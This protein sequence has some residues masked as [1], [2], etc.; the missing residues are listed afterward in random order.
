MNLRL[1]HINHPSFSRRFTQI[2]LIFC[3]SYTSVL[4][5]G[6]E[7][8]F[9]SSSRTDE[10]QAIIQT[11]D[12]GYLSV[13]ST[14]SFGS[15]NDT[16][17]FVVKTDVD[18]TTVWTQFYDEAF[19]E[20]AYDVVQ[21][22]DGGFL[23]V[24]DYEESP[25]VLKDAYLIKISASGDFL[26]SK[27]L[28]HDLEETIASITPGI[29]G[30]FLLAGES[31]DPISGDS[32]FLLIKIDDEGNEAWFKTIGSDQND[33]RINAITSIDNQYVFVGNT[34]RPN[35]FDNDVAVRAVDINGDPIWEGDIKSQLIEEGNDIISTT[36]GALV[37]TGMIGEGGNAF[38]AK[39]SSAGEQQWLTTIP[40]PVDGQSSE[41][42]TAVAELEN[43]N[44]TM[45]G[46]AEFNAGVNIDIF[47]A[48]L[49]KDGEVLWTNTTGDKLN[50]DFGQD[51]TATH[52]GGYI[53]TGFNSSLLTFVNDLSLIK[54]DGAGNT[55]TS[56]IQGSIFGEFCNNASPTGDFP[57]EGWLVE[58]VSQDFS[59][60]ASTNEKGEF[61][62]RVDTG[63]YTIK[64]LPIS[65]YWKSCLPGGIIRNVTKFYDT[66]RV[67]LQVAPEINCPY[68]EVDVSTP[69]LA[70]C[71]EIT[72]TISYC[73][74]GTSAAEDAYIEV[75]LDEELTFEASD[76]P[77]S[78]KVD[79]LYRFEVGDLPVSLC[80]NFTITTS[81]AC[82]GIAQGQSTFVAARIFPDSIC[83]EPDPL[84][85]QSSII[86]GGDCI[87]QDSVQFFIK[88]VGEGRME[89]PSTAVVI[90]ADIIFWQRSIQ[91]GSQ[92]VIS[93]PAFPVNGFPHR[94]VAAQSPGHPGRSYPTLAIEGCGSDGL[95]QTGF[96]TQ[97]AEDDQDPWVSINMQ[98]I[99]GPI[100]DPAVLVGNPKGYREDAL[101]SPETNLKYTIIFNNT[102]TDTVTRLVVRDTLPT[103]LDITSIQLGAS[104]HP[105]RFEVYDTGILKFTF[106]QIDLPPSSS[107]NPT[108][109][110]Y[111]TYTVQ[112][113]QGNLSGTQIDHRA[114][115]FFE[116]Y[117]PI[118]TNTVSHQVGSADLDFIEIDTT[119]TITSAHFDEYTFIDVTVQPNPFSQ[120]TTFTI[121]NNRAIDLSNYQLEILDYTGRI[122]K[123]INFVGNQ[124]EL[125][126]T[127]LSAGLYLYRL[128]NR[129]NSQM[130][131]TGKIIVE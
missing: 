16:D 22:S 117:A 88:N 10:G 58:A 29:D 113:N 40:A 47:M 81:L 1:S 12:L 74:I 38:I 121:S 65:E 94:I 76:I 118:I 45:V 105:Y 90:E 112:Q 32:D 48:G 114:A 63:E 69:F 49:S 101:I 82:E 3:I 61:L 44:L 109:I 13:G 97:Y 79:S 98:E 71:S 68:L 62:I 67:D 116:N 52:D 51:I 85:D 20:R 78:A 2:I 131:S 6:W 104:S 56:F 7:R 50:T 126:G 4:G 46:F 110:G 19:Q 83:T 130:I 37:I 127:D 30:G 80:G 129:M 24:G 43:G 89:K 39:Y 18:G 25:G 111:L 106:D 8:N 122:I 128:A 75:V 125:N 35:G 26:W 87:G 102:T 42:G 108:S 103:E 92:E 91:L 93:T 11:I 84:W 28:E 31:R 9:G 115:V 41:S 95:I 86:V 96:V 36:D 5:Q 66:T 17:I 21:T 27:V 123:S 99:N 23:I 73:N 33:D 15:D 34:E 77:F 54:T 100:T 70:E 119:N 72:Y 59:Y 55:T 14:E 57:K 53:I 60:I 107:T 64:A 120:N 124:Y